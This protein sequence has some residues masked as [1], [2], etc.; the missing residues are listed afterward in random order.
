M[1]TRLVHEDTDGVF[2]RYDGYK[3]R[4]Q[5]SGYARLNSRYKKG[6]RPDMSCPQALWYRGRAKVGVE[7]WRREPW[8]T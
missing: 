2:V 4:P 6:D 7:Y 3:F 5:V 1:A 8:E